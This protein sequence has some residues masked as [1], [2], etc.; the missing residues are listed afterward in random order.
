[1]GPDLPPDPAPRL[2][3]SPAPDPLLSLNQ[4][5]ADQC[6]RFR[7]NSWARMGVPPLLSTPCHPFPHLGLR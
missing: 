6:P 5:E 3:V 7:A 1:M 4:A 2:N